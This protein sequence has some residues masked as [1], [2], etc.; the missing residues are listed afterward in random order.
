MPLDQMTDCQDFFENV[1][2]DKALTQDKSFRLYIISLRE[3]RIK[4]AIRRFLWIPTTAMLADCLTKLFGDA[5]T[6]ILITFLE[7]GLTRITFCEGS[8]RKAFCEGSWRKELAS[9]KAG[10]LK[11][12]SVPDPSQWHPQWETEYDTAGATMATRS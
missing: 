8:W 9:K 2:G 10:T 11:E 12:L 1:A 5:S 7:S 3:D 6:E 4:Q